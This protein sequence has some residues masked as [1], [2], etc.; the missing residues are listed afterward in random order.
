MV[1]HGIAR[2]DTAWHGMARGARA[3]HS[4][5]HWQMSGFMDGGG[6]VT[7][8]QLPYNLL[9]RALEFEIAPKCSAD[10][11]G[12]LAYGPFQARL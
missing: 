6:C 8:N 3:Q 5:T 10:G 11:W 7:T 1:W 12:I 4:M 9:W 2:H